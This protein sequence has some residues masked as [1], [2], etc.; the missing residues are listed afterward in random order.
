MRSL[1]SE[2]ADRSALDSWLGYVLLRSHLPVSLAG[3]QKRVDWENPFPQVPGRPIQDQASDMGSH[4]SS[5]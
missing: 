3:Q 1:L 2:G 4:T 5:A